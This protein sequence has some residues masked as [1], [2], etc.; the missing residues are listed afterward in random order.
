MNALLLAE[1]DNLLLWA[2]WVVLNLIDG[3]DDSSF[4]KQLLQVLDG[5]VGDTNGLDLFGM[6]LDQL[7]KVLPCV[8]V[9]YGVVNIARAVFML[10]EQRVVAC[11]C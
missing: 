11:D 8:L 6:R 7:L 1:V 9:G 10:G 5:V 4:G 2:K 3:G